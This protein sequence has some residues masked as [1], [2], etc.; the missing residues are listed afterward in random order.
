MS[1]L[2]ALILH[3]T[4]SARRKAIVSPASCGLAVLHE[5]T[6]PTCLTATQLRLA[7]ATT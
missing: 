5:T 6:W 7:A 2:R 3:S 1:S 4:T